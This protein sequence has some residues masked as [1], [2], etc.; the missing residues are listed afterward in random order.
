MGVLEMWCEG[1]CATMKGRR[2]SLLGHCSGE[3]EGP[4]FS[5]LR[6]GSWRGDALGDDQGNEKAPGL[7]HT[8]TCL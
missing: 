3:E 8:N 1:L 5:G 7:D 2:D 6:L 4:A